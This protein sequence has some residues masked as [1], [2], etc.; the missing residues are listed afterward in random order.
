MRYQ[1][2]SVSQPM[3][4]I[5]AANSFA[6]RQEFAKRYGLEV[7]ECM[8]RRDCDHDFQ[9]DPKCDLVDVCSKCGEERA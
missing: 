9:P 6:A 5:E 4:H 2:W 1:T 8:S 7:T 3:E